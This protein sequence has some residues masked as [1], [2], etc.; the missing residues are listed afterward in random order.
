[1]PIDLTAAHQLVDVRD[2]AASILL[3]QAAVE[4]HVLLK[5]TNN[6]LPLQKPRLLSLFGYDGIIPA[7]NTPGAPGISK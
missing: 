7:Q 1:M 4:G 2:P 5:N 3:H 6:A